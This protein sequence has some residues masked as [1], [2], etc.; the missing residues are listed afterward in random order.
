MYCFCYLFKILEFF[1]ISG[2]VLYFLLI[3]WLICIK[4]DDICI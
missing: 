1:E 4:V 3:I 2:I